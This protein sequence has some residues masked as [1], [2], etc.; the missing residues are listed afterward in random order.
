MGESAQVLTSN[1]H[2]N[3]RLSCKESK[4]NS[5]E[6]R[7]KKNFVDTI[8][9]AGFLEHVQGERQSRQ[10]TTKYRELL[11]NLVEQIVFGY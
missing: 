10:D 2:D 3:Q 6:N 8:A 7:C 11:R 5:A 1:A 9:L 4:Y